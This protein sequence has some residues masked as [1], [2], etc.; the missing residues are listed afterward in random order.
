MTKNIRISSGALLLGLLIIPPVFAKQYTVEQN[1]KMFIFNG[2]AA[3]AINVK[4]GDEISF[5]NSDT[6]FHNIYS[7][8]DVMN[9]NLGAY[10][11]GES[12]SVVFNKVGTVKVKCAIHPR[13]FIDVKVEN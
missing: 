3:S 4:Q 1:N 5:K 12:A 6:V 10:G 2:S 7:I 8:S 11:G 9:F 13:M